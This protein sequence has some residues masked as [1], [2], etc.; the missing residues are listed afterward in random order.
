M[1]PVMYAQ[2]E[3][4]EQ[5]QNGMRGARGM[6]PVDCRRAWF[7]GE[8]TV[9]CIAA[10]QFLISLSKHLSSAWDQVLKDVDI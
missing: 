8:S 2:W 1:G 6:L 9:P 3:F 10:L 5:M 7:P 4:V